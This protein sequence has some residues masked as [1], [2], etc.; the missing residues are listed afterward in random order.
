MEHKQEV[1]DFWA[2]EAEQIA[3]DCG[4]K[5]H[6]IREFVREYCKRL[7][8]SEAVE[9]AVYKEFVDEFPSSKITKNYFHTVVAKSWET[10]IDNKNVTII[11]LNK[12]KVIKSR[13]RRKI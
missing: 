13:K 2:K 7:Q 11:K 10:G 5:A 12:Q 3:G 1:Y 6:K 8:L 4:Y 9:Y